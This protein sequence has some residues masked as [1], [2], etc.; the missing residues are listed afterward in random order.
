MLPG[1]FLLQEQIFVPHWG[2]NP[3]TGHTQIFSLSLTSQQGMYPQDWHIAPFW[4]QLKVKNRNKH[5]CFP[6]WVPM[7]ED[8]PI[9]FVSLH[10]STVLSLLSTISIW[11]WWERKCDYFCCS[12]KIHSSRKRAVMLSE[13]LLWR[14]KSRGWWGSSQ[15][16]WSTA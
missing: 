13:R 10:L 1:R 11:M 2:W 15:V 6:G 7:L 9:L 16:P 8:K 12:A 5:L 3:N 14:T 4:K